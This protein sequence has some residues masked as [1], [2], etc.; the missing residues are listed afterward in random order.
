MKIMSTLSNILLHKSCHDQNVNGIKEALRSGAN[1]N[2]YFKSG[3]TPLT[4]L[5]NNRCVAGIKLL[6]E[7]GA[8]LNQKTKNGL[9]PVYLACSEKLTDVLA[10]LLELSVEVNTPDNDGITPLHICCEDYFKEGLE[11]LLQA[12]AN[13]HALSKT[14][15]S[16]LH[17]ACESGFT[18]AVKKLVQLG[19]DCNIKDKY[20]NTPLHYAARGNNTE[21]INILLECTELNILDG[22]NSNKETAL[23]FAVMNDNQSVVKKLLRRGADATVVNNFGFSAIHYV[24]S[25]EVLRCL[26]QKGVNVNEA[27][28]YSGW[29]PLHSC[30][31]VIDV[32][33]CLIENGANINAQALS[34][35]TPLLFAVRDGL[36]KSVEILLRAGANPNI[37]NNKGTNITNNKGTNN[38]GTTPLHLTRKANITKLLLNYG[39]KSSSDFL[40]YTPLHFV[41]ESGDIESI[42]LI[43]EH[44]TDINAKTNSSMTA[45]CCAIKSCREDAVIELLKLGVNSSYSFGRL[46]KRFVKEPL[47]SI[48]LENMVWQHHK[49]DHNIVI[50]HEFKTIQEMQKLL[51]PLVNPKYKSKRNALYSS[52]RLLSLPWY[53]RVEILRYVTTNPICADWGRL[54]FNHLE[55]Y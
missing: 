50:N 17:L 41:A 26:L 15:L 11:M 40:G 49:L 22:G 51:Q 1:P 29:T 2:S 55:K 38:K 34:G 48:L 54:E 53:L 3:M 47:Y 16:P 14:G 6:L 27:N 18:M 32:V 23:M 39:A 37:T 7:Y 35:S 4:I 46:D 31:N 33:Q 19:V 21:V 30:L 12:G 10:L 24:R 52:S 5:C 28:P 13:P 36:E 20:F 43:G 8:D 9:A 25:T 44:T 42:C 45:L